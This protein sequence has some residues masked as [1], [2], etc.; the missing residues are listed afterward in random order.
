MT[1]QIKQVV[2]EVSNALK[3]FN[4]TLATAESCTGGGL[5]Y[6]LTAFPG[7]S[8]CFERGFVTYSDEAKCE[9]LAVSPLTLESFG[10][11]SAETAREMAEGAI[12]NS[13]ADLSI[14]VTGLAG[15]DGGTAEK[16]VGL[17]WIAIAERDFSTEVIENFFTGTREEIRNQTIVTALSKL[18]EILMMKAKK[19]PTF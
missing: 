15:P 19:M 8:T 13:K 10:A 4:L 5:A 9:M 14:A 6:W 16:P 1:D 18:L 17:V 3:E 11:V 2:K 12:D 7:S